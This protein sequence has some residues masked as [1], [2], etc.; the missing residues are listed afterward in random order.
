MLAHLGLAQHKLFSSS[1]D[2]LDVLLCRCRARVK[3]QA[4]LMDQ[5]LPVGL[6]PGQ[7]LVIKQVQDVDQEAQR[8]LAEHE[9]A[10]LRSLAGRPFAPELYASYSSQEAEAGTGD[11]C[12]CANLIIE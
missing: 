6:E 9:E 1:C 11:M 8:Q 5:Q 12:Q 3:A 7:Q 10:V 2:Q 4:D